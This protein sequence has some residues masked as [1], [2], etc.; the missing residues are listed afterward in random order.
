MRTLCEI[1]HLEIL[2]LNAHMWFSNSLVVRL[3]TAMKGTNIMTF[4][5]DKTEGVF[6]AEDHSTL[7]IVVVSTTMIVMAIVSI[8]L[9]V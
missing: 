5:R 2:Q 3:N 9:F 7:S 1:D 4:P 8:N 6:E